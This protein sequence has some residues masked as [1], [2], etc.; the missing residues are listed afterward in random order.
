LGNS[1]RKRPAVVAV[2]A[3]P[4]MLIAYVPPGNVTVP[5]KVGLF[6]GAK[7]ASAASALE[8]SAPIA[9]VTFTVRATSKT[10]TPES[11]IFPKPSA[12]IISLALAVVT[13]VVAVAAVNVL[14]E[15]ST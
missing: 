13:F 12:I 11:C 7:S 4:L 2:A 5:V 14:P 10:D 3:L 8:V 9:V 6:F 15:P 1:A